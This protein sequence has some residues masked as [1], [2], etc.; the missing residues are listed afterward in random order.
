MVNREGDG[1]CYVFSPLFEIKVFLGSIFKVALRCV[2]ASL[3]K[4][5]C[6]FGR[7]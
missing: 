5:A 6:H 7:C 1:V 2:V 4:V 3:I